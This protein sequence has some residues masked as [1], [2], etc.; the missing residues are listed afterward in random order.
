MPYIIYQTTAEEI[1]SATDAILLKHNGAEIQLIAD[2]LTTTPVNA[3]NAVEMAVELGLVSIDNNQQYV[4]KFPYANYLVTSIAHQKAAILRL[5]LE[6]YYPYKLFKSRLQLNDSPVA[7]ANQVKTILSLTAHQTEIS[8]TFISLGTYTNSLNT[9]GAGRYS[10]NIND[11]YSF[12][13]IVDEVIG[14]R[15]SAELKIRSRLGEAISQWV[16]NANVLNPLTTAFQ[17][18]G[19]ANNDQRAPIVHAGN[20]FESFLTQ[21][22]GLNAININ[23]SH[24]INAKA[25]T[26]RNAGHFT[27]KHHNICKYLGHIRNAC[28]HGLDTDIGHSWSISS[29]T[30]VEYVHVCLSAIRSIYDYTQGNYII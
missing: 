9:L 21:V 12:I 4:P 28:D 2:F 10:P 24:G 17:R 1:I 15:Q 16:D 5:I 30:A 7:S 14:D 13:K 20:A 3:Q 19:D 25:D 29:D 8:Q 18:A 6:E 27:I 22:A 23:N 11:N 26:L